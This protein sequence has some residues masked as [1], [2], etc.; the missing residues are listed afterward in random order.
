[1]FASIC[2]ISGLLLLPSLCVHVGIYVVTYQGCTGPT[3]FLQNVVALRIGPII[4]LE[5][6]TSWWCSVLLLRKCE[7][8]LLPYKDHLT[9]CVNVGV[10]D[11]RRGL[12]VCPWSFLLR[13]SL[14]VPLF[15]DR[16]DAGPRVKL[17]LFINDHSWF[18]CSYPAAVGGVSSCVHSRMDPVCVQT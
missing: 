5:H 9:S 8:H 18:D 15:M 13:S 3:T 11:S 16:G 14:S 2:M 10:D 4:L 7:Q 17:Q 1:M 12:L 6:R